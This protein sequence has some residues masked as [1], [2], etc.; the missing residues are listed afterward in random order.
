MGLVFTVAILLVVV[1]GLAYAIGI[2]NGL[3]QVNQ[4]VDKAWANIDVLLKQR[5]DEIPK[6]IA[7]CEG[8]KNFERSTLESVI[9][10]RAEYTN[11]STANQKVAAAG[12]LTGAVRGLLA[13]AEQYPD[14]KSS[15][16]FMQLQS[17]ISALEEQIA[18]RREF[19]NDSVTVLNTRIRQ[20]P[21]VFVAPILQIG[22][23]TM[24][25]VSEAD[26]EDVKIQ[27][28]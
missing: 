22:P 20:I 2:Y 12:H 3:V 18:D 14:L 13:V 1:V 26:R 19:Y 21:D 28:K 8:Y 23:R 17:R 25:Q 16:N 10:A 6:L 5:H 27:F 4:N 9:K 24:Y 7:T 15:A 11:A